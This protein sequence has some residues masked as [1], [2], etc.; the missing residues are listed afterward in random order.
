MSDRESLDR[1]LSQVAQRLRLQRTLREL[2]WAA[3]CIAGAFLVYQIAV[4]TI[5]A[6]V[7]LVA[8]RGAL[9][10]VV[11]VVLGWCGVRLVRTATLDDAAAAADA[12]ADLKDELKS[13]RWFAR[14]PVESAFDPT[15]RGTEIALTALQLKRANA[16]AQRL[17]PADIV[18]ISVPRPLWL[19]VPVALAAAL[20]FWFAP[21]W[22]LA[23]PPADRAAPGLSQV[24]AAEPNRAAQLNGAATQ[25]GSRSRDAAGDKAEATSTAP[26][27]NRADEPDWSKAEQLAKSL[28]RTERAYE[29]SRAI[30]AR[31]SKRAAQLVREIKQQEQE[32]ASAKI[33]RP[34]R[35]G[36]TR[37]LEGTARDTLSALQ[38]IFSQ[39]VTGQGLDVDK[40]G[41]GDS[42]RPMQAGN[43]RGD[44]DDRQSPQTMSPNPNQGSD[45][46]TTREG[47]EEG[48]FSSNGQ[49]EGDNP[50]GNSNVA[51][52]AQGQHVTQS[53]SAVDVP[54]APVI[55]TKTTRLAAQIQRVRIESES[56]A[57]PAGK[58]AE[59]RLYSATRAQ[60]S[61]LDYRAVANQPR[62]T[63]EAAVGGE[64][65]PLEHR[66]LVKDYFLNQRQNEK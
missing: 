62:Y 1:S 63:K 39:K 8:A 42:G 45:T 23:Q 38:D 54:T 59:E 7:V 14:H 53:A 51:E 41:G 28:G 27:R 50:G 56:E 55:G 11:L 66:A 22:L 61:L 33:D 25:P 6:S 2:G 46:Q 40:S 24:N 35:Q 34:I 37:S 19:A 44:E 4:A 13:A 43:N 12:H 18:P 32:R 58:D 31:D 52:G 9:A 60:K 57:Q 3:L 47:K 20:L 17:E 65:V 26:G 21:R 16:N 15:K 10:L 64:R 5:A 36:T 49:G 29:L 30:Q 48:E